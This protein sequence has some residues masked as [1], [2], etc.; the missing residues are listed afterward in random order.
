MTH[1]KDERSM[2]PDTG[3][4]PSSDAV[5]DNG[6]QS[7]NSSSSDNHNQAQP[8]AQQQSSQG[9]SSDSNLTPAAF[10]PGIQMEPTPSVQEVLDH[11]R[12][13]LGKPVANK[14]QDNI[15]TLRE[16]YNDCSDIIIHEFDILN[17][18]AAALAY[19]DGL[20]D[21][22]LIDTHIL[23]PLQQI[24]TAGSRDKDPI[25]KCVTISAMLEAADFQIVSDKISYGHA[26]LLIDGITSALVY[27]VINPIIRSIEEPEAET[28]VRGPREGFVESIRTNSTLL[29][30]RLHTPALKMKPVFIG[31]YTKTAAV[32]TFIEGIADPNLVKE[33]EGRLSA[34]DVDGMTD[35]S[36]IEEWIEDN[37]FSPFPQLMSTERPDVVTAH[38]LEGKIALI[39]DGSPVALIAPASLMSMMQSPEDFYQR[40]LVATAIRW[41]R[42]LFSLI[43]IFGP[44][45][46]VAVLS[47]HQEMLPTSLLLTIAVSREQ[48]P[49]PALVEALLME[50]TFEA[51]R[52]AGIRLPRQVGSAVSIVGALVIGQ[53]AISA[54]IV[55]SPMVMVVAITAVS[56]FLIP[57]YSL[58]IA[59]RFIRFPIMLCAGALGLYGIV[60]AALVILIHLMTLRSFGVPYLSPLSPMQT[61]QLKDTL[62]RTSS[63]NAIT[64]PHLTGSFF[65]RVRMRTAL[66]KAR[67]NS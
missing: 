4:A 61:S 60:L 58:G 30:R 25:V 54:G 66:Y 20:S 50:I 35:T 21:M 24:G 57:N 55:S 47:Y 43:T 34:I 28:V 8:T 6:N 10:K 41:L 36:L 19:I 3:A 26:V 53:A 1:P 44:S 7:A 9:Q 23:A 46:Y 5:P 37:P 39:A 38:L 27:D 12:Q 49:F 40:S 11:Q 22:R 52:E 64:R 33:M 59:I 16:L 67:R 42:M 32:I 65:N 15:D 62:I 29:R 48:I 31:R 2:Q 51:L 45:F 17:G 18:P 63:P 56:S 14:L 13:L